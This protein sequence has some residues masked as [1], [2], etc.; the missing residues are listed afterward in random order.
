MGNLKPEIIH[1]WKKYSSTYKKDFVILSCLVDILII[2]RFMYGI[3]SN[4]I[5]L[6]FDAPN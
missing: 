6:V 1:L 2:K 5:L 4:N 3:L